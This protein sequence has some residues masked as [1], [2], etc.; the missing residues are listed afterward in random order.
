MHDIRAIRENPAAFE[1]ALSRRGL[2]GVSAQVLALDE[3]RR[4]RILASET[5]QAAQNA[6]S[7][8]AGAAKARGDEAEFNRLRG[9]RDRE[10]GRNRRDGRRGRGAGRRSAQP[11]DGHPQP[12]ARTKSPMARTRMTTSKSAAGATRAIST[13]PR[14]NIST[15]QASNPAWISKPP[16][17]SPAHALLF[18]KVP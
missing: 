13:S 17:N 9:A 3:S 7:K 12:A 5:A 11:A 16:P 1:A 4:A 6:A 10:K 15:S 2:S 8:E 14:L 18:S